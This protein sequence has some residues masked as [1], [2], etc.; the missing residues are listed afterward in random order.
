MRSE[1]SL[2]RRNVNPFPVSAFMLC[3]L[4]LAACSN[5]TEPK[6]C[7][8][9]TG[10][11][12]PAAPGFLVAYKS[13]IDPVAVTSQLETKYQFQARYV[14]T[15]PAGFGALLTNDVLSAVRCESAVAAIEH[16]AVASLVSH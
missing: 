15:S 11:F 13:G 7:V 5:G 2:A 3:L 14:W 1:T 16:D 8:E 10:T 4:A 12:N 9:V 6:G